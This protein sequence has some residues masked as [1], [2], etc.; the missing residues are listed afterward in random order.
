MD[1]NSIRENI[2]RACKKHGFTKK[3][4]AEAIGLSKVSFHALENG[5]T[6]ILNENVYKIADFLGISPEELIL[7]YKPDPESAGLLVEAQADYGRKSEMLKEG[8]EEKLDASTRENN[9]L[10]ALVE[11]QKETI[12]NQ[13]EIIS[14]LRRRIPEEN[15]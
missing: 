3:A 8:Y 15:D 5:P 11:S 13:E 6:R 12:R 9:T 7:G 2:T 1:E 10:L 4:V 14:M